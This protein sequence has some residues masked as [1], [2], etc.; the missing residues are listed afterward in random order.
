M[1]RNLKWQKGID[2]TFLGIEDKTSEERAITLCPY[3]SLVIKEAL[4]HAS[5]KKRVKLVDSAIL[6]CM[7]VNKSV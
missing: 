7:K 2:L 6:K 4:S 5:I 3:S 1:Q